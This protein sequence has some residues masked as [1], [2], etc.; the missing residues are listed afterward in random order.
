MRPSPKFGIFEKDSQVILMQVLHGPH[1][2][3]CCCKLCI[4]SFASI[5]EEREV[6]SVCVDISKDHFRIMCESP[7]ALPDLDTVTRRRLHVSMLSAEP[8]VLLTGS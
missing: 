2:E 8:S 4:L 6:A 7:R 1:F 3:E 5:H